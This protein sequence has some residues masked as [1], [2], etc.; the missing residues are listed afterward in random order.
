[1]TAFDLQFIVPS[2]LSII[3]GTILF[4]W[5]GFD[6]LFADADKKNIKKMK[7]GRYFL[8]TF[9]VFLGVAVILSTIFDGPT[10]GYI[11]P[12]TH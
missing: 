10:M 2:S 12:P 3:A 4:R 7:Y 5:S 9:C 11:I 6:E 8:A 1:M